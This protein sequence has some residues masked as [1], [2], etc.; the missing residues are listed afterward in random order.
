MTG[1]PHRLRRLRLLTL[2]VLL[3]AAAVQAADSPSPAPA[4]NDP[5]GAA[6]SQIASKDWAGALAEL[7]RVNDSASANWN[8]LMGYTLR[9]QRT[10]DLD[11]AERHYKEALRLDPKHRGAHEYIGELYLMRGD[12]KSAE[13]HLAALDKLCLLPCEEYDDLKKAVA[14]FKANGNKHVPS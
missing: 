14:R 5:L 4:A 2:G 12:L 13:G 6:R 10:P 1:S 11:T 8:N 9:K 3:G 7:R